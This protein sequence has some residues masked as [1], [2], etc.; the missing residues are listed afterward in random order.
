MLRNLLCLLI[1]LRDLRGL[2]TV[3]EGLLDQMLG[4]LSRLARRD[5]RH[6]ISNRR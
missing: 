6:G 1:V 3:L 2:L 4:N 5:G